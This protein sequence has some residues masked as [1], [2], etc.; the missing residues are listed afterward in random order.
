MT[1]H[2]EWCVCKD[3]RARDAQ[4]KLDD[5]LFAEKAHISGWP[6]MG[7]QS[8]SIESLYQAFKRRLVQE[9]SA[10]GEINFEHLPLVD[11]PQ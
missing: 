1:A 5:E 2:N 6:E 9:L 10:R 4:Q 11:K 3:C 8:V 7:Q